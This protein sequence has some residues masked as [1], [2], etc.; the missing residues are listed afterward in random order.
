[1]GSVVVIVVIGM[2]VEG[3]VWRR[4]RRW[5]AY[6]APVPPGGIPRETLA[7]RAFMRGNSCLAEGKF[8]E[9][10]AAFHQARELEPKRAHVAERLAEVEWRQRVASA[11]PPVTAS[12]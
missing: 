9:A 4:R 12:C 6:A 10:S 1:M 11:L 5:Q 7:L 2:L 8:T 3:I